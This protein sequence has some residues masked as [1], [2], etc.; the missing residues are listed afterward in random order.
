MNALVTVWILM[1]VSPDGAMTRIATYRTPAACSA[2]LPEQIP[3]VPMLCLQATQLLPQTYYQ[4][5]K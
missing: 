4:R 2:I 3:G 5:L 1:S